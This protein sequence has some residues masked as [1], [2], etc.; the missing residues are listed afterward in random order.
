MFIEDVQGCGSHHGVPHGILLI[1]ESRVGTW[2]HI[3]QGAP[4]VYNQSHTFFRVAAVHDLDVTVQQLLHTQSFAQG[5]IVFLPA[6]VQGAALM[7]PNTAG[8]GIVVQGN[9]IHITTSK[10]HDGIGPV[11][12]IYIGATGNLIELIIAVVVQIGLIAA[13]LISVVFR[14]HIAAAAPVL[15]AYAKIADFPG[16][17]LAI[18]HPQLCHGGNTIKC[19]V[20]HPFAHFLDGTRSQVA[21]NIR[22]TAYLAT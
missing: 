18:F 8:N 9:G 4:F 5:D 17:F 6:E 1:E 12:V 3:V 11:V 19:H 15:V 10:L 21:V 22:L 20:F 16:L 13:E 7:L 14:A 2:F